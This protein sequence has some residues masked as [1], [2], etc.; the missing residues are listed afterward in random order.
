M[1]S[2][3]HIINPVNATEGSELFIAQP[4]VFESM[5]K[6]KAFAENVD[7]KLFS[8]QYAED[9]EVVPDYFQKTENLENSILPIAIGINGKKKLPLIK[10]ILS[11]IYE[12]PIA[13]GAT[14]E[15]FI[16][17]NTDIIVLPQFYETVAKIIEQGYDAFI[18]NRR[19]IPKVYN[20][21]NDLP[22]IYSDIGKSHPGFD[23]FIFKRELFPKFILGEICVGIPF[24][25]ATMMHN[26]FAHAEKCKL[27]DDLHLTTH[28]GMNVMPKRDEEYYLHNRKEFE[29]IKRELMP[30][31]SVKKMPYSEDPFL[32][33]TFKKGLN[34]AV[35]TMMNLEL[36][37]KSVGE[38]IR[39]LW[40]ELRFRLL[41]K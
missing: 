8:A 5:R 33:R 19:R 38:K 4:I 41:K 16:Y 26:L 30:L 28:I 17:T 11:R 37:K 23:C 9:S 18:I 22:F 21:V 15:Y 10:D 2:I 32:L 34:P 14:A 3:T 24:V 25:E 40:N 39:F 12:T 1:I 13:I 31:L 29:K 6:A 7:V 36:E 27:F 35:F 20:S